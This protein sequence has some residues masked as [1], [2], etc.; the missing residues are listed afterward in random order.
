MNHEVDN[1]TVFQSEQQAKQS[2]QVST[3]IALT[4][5]SNAMNLKIGKFL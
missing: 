3:T 4:P 1:E 5:K 2:T